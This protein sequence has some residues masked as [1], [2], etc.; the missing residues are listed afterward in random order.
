[1][2]HHKN[3]D[4]IICYTYNHKTISDPFY[5]QIKY[6]IAN[7]FNWQCK[8]MQAYNYDFESKV[9]LNILKKGNFWE[10]QVNTRVEAR[11][12]RAQ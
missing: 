10:S 4:E 7:N 8:L 1:M 3:T 2:G 6:A 11:V 5:A 9:T 12:F